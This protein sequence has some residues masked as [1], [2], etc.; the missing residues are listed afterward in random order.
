[1]LVRQSFRERLH[2]CVKS[3]SPAVTTIPNEWKIKL[4]RFSKQKR[5]V[6]AQKHPGLI[7]LYLSLTGPR[8]VL[9]C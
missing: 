3:A 4:R 7:L 9:R 5:T 2:E 6:A 1:M 8:V